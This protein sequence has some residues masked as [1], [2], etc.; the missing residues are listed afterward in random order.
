MADFLNKLS[1]FPLQARSREKQGT[2]LEGKAE[3]SVC[4]GRMTLFSKHLG[5]Y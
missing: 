2:G 5:L 4:A 3:A 1:F